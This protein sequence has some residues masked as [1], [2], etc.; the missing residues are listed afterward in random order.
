MVSSPGFQMIGGLRHE[1]KIKRSVVSV[2]GWGQQ[3]TG[4]D[5]S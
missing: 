4:W 1:R 3:K 5:L 2:P